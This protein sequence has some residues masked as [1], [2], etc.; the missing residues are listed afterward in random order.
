MSY[1]AKSDPDYYCFPAFILKVTGE[2][3]PVRE[4]VGTLFRLFPSV[5]D[6]AGRQIE[7]H[8]RDLFDGEAADLPD[9]LMRE[10]QT[11]EAHVEPTL[12]SDDHVCAG[13]IHAHDGVYTACYYT[14]K[15][16]RME[17]VAT[18]KKT[19]ET[20]MC[21]TSVLVPLLREVLLGDRQ[22]LFHAAALA[23]PGGQGMLFF[24]DSGGGK[25]TTSLALMRLGARL[26]ADDLVM[27]EEKDSA[28]ML[29]SF[30]EPLNLTEQTIAFFDE[31]KHLQASPDSPAPKTAVSPQGI[32]GE[33]CF[34]PSAPLCV[35][36]IVTKSAGPPRVER[37]APN[38]SLGY[39]LRAHTFA[40]CQTISKVA[41]NIIY[42]LIESVPI[43]RLYTGADPAALGQWLLDK[44]PDHAKGGA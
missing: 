24:A 29:H 12:I 41:L 13:F 21:I 7:L 40:R 31:L 18:R 42:N 11:P 5:A 23:S 22:A 10:L 8:V 9:F 30:P 6:G 25:T 33:T 2:A 19:G 17:F 26:L 32:Y 36:Y 34:Q 35:A 44:A 14:P 15:D 28:L 27:V 1:D 4:A 20:A 16:S 39:M 43:Y 3:S 37:V 38:E